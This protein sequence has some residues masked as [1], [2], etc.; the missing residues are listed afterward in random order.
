MLL[1]KINK[2]EFLKPLQSVA[3]IV[4]RRH[5]LPI[6][7]NVL[8][9][10]GNQNIAFVATDLEIQITAMLENKQDNNESAIT[11]S[12]K[13]L[14]DI[15]R[16]LPENSEISF[17]SKDSRLQLR[18]GKSQFNLQ[19]LPAEDFPKLALS[20]ELVSEISISQTMLKQLFNQVQYAMA[21]QD[22]RYYLNGLLLVLEPGFVKV[23]ATDGHRLSLASMSKETINQSAEAILPRKTVTELIKLLGDTEEEVKINLGK[24]LVT[25]TFG[26]INL[27]SKV[28][29]GKF[30]DYNKVIPSNYNNHVVLDR[31]TMLHAMQR[32]SIL[33]N[34]KFRGVRMVLTQN[35]MRVICNNTE[36]EE[37]EE[38][39]EIEYVDEPLDIGFNVTY[40][41]DVLNNI[42]TK[43]VDCSFGDAN[44]SCLITV[45]GDDRFKYV[46]MP[47]RI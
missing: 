17:S 27:V 26:N 23:V 6:L 46:V 41:L 42:N 36:Q 30:P 4:E 21:Q 22:I 16:A 38:E 1:M 34:E 8:I 44:S 7:S 15:V 9:Q 11:V 10:I 13:K 3:G 33:S 25:F 20:D 24:N 19:T 5:T 43:E 12:A 47:M 29:E 35:S 45:P 14:Q 18:A 31:L 37:A 28:I 40:L 39:L 2:E 32:A